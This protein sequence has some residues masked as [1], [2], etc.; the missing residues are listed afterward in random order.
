MAWNQASARVPKV[1]VCVPIVDR[2][3]L[4][5]AFSFAHIIADAGGGGVQLELF[6][7]G[8]YAVDYARNDLVDQS[9]RAGCSHTFFLDADIFPYQWGLNDKGQAVGQHCSA[10]IR[11]MLAFEYPIVT[12]LYWLKKNPGGPNIADI[13]DSELFQLRQPRVPVKDLIGSNFFSDACGFGCVLIDNRVFGKIPYPWF[14]FHRS[15]E[16]NAEGRFESLG[17]DYYFG[18][19][20]KAHGFPILS[21]GAFICKHEGD[22]YLGWDGEAEPV[23]T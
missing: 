22:F 4:P 3:S 2:P 13:V 14:V 23:L 5:W 20:A 1:A 16:R 10:I 9:L 17:E 15:K 12:A 6:Y 7:N 19:K 21:L 18:R 11:Q 8:Q